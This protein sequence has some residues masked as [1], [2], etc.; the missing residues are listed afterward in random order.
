[1]ISAALCVLVALC[2]ILLSGELRG[3]KQKSLL[4]SEELYALVLHVKRQV[5]CY[6]RPI[7]E[8]LKDYSS[9]TLEGVGFLP[10]AKERGLLTALRECEGLRISDEERR[11]LLSLFSSLGAGYVKDE[12]KLIE[13]CAAELYKLLLLR[14]SQIPKDIKLINTLCVSGA[15]GI[16]ILMV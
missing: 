12:V 14:R 7:A 9:P 5:G 2:S 1:M 13:D 16:L 3:Y 8:L 6:L 10:M 11:L 4:I 15:L